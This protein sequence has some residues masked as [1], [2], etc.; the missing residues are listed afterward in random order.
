[1]RWRRKN[2]IL[3]VPFAPDRRLR[4]AAGRL[5]RLRR[6]A[7]RGVRRGAAADD[8]QGRAADLRAPAPAQPALPSGPADRRPLARHRTRHQRHREPCCGWR[9]STSCRRCSKCCWSPRSC[10]GCSIGGSR[11]LTFG[12]VAIYIGFTFVFT[13]WRVKFRRTMNEMDSDAQT[14]AIDCLL[15]YET[16]KYFG[17]EAHETRRFDAARARYE[18][19]AVRSQVTLNMLNLGQAAIIAIGLGAR[20]ADG[21]RRRAGRHDDGRPVRAGQHLSDAALPAAELP[22]LRL[23]RDQA[24]AGGHGIDVPPHVGQPGGR[25]PARRLALPPQLADGHTGSVTFRDVHFGYNAEPRDPQ[26]RQLRRCRRAPS[27]PSSAR[28]APASRPSAACCSA[29]TT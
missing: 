25:R 16:V 20:H 12:A 23:S 24:G 11:S 6:A 5:L 3:T 10:G 27:S 9:C 13:N 28:P 19:A 22:R 17:N 4:P 21:G 1:M 8:P 18:R 7:R 14:K 15:N 2:H 29:S 26:G